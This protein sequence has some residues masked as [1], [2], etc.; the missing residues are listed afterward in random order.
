MALR[1]L[2]ALA[3]TLLAGLVGARLVG[4]QEAARL[5]PAR[6]GLVGAA[7]PG[8]GGV[9]TLTLDRPVP[10]RVEPDRAGR[11]LAVAFAGLAPPPPGAVPGLR[12]E[13]GPPGW[14]RLVLAP[15]A[16][17]PR[18]LTLRSAGM[19]TD[20]PDGAAR[21][22]LLLDPAPDAAAPLP[23]RPGDDRITVMLD[24]GHGGV[25]PGAVR[26]G[27]READIALAFARALR[28]A[29]RREGRFRVEMT[30]DADVFVSLEG[31]VAAARDAG[32]DVF[33]S[34]HADA[35]AEG[36]A[37]GAQV[38]TLADTASSQAGARLAERH[39]RTGLVDGLDLAGQDDA[40]AG[41]L[42]D[43]ARAETAPRTDALAD[44]LV[45]GL[46]AG[47]IA[48]HPKPRARAAFSVLKAPDMPSVLVEIGFM[49]SPGELERL[50]DPAWRARAAAALAAGLADW[51][52]ADAAARRVGR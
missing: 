43:L 39:D 22:T 10:W 34:L 13:P 16:A 51:A 31:R 52:A 36:V 38:W 32:A 33:V 41:V 18:G 25:D 9:L 50:R 14:T 46:G 48:L 23:A 42:M 47:G 27:V 2:A 37:R 44:A 19:E 20:L 28:E 24:P 7:A 5:D 11:P 15:A 12:A 29:L 21:V 4:A 6:S 30:R 26:D 17:G 45:A 3:L 49:S 1:L 35:L 40:V 8:E